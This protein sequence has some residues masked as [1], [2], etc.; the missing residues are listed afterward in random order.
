MAT[1]PW[2]TTRQRVRDAAGFT[3]RTDQLV[4]QAIAAASRIVE[5]ETHRRF[6]PTTATR[7][8]DWPPP[9]P[10]K[11][12]RLWLD[13]D[14]L[15][16]LT[17]LTI[18]GT[19]ATVSEFNLEPANE[20]P[21]YNRIEVDLSTSAAFSAGTT[22]QQAISIVGVW[23]FENRTIPAG[24]TAEDMTT[25]ETDL[26]VTNGGLIDVGDLLHIGDERLFVT[27]VAFEDTT[28]NT[29]DTMSADKADTTVPVADETGF[30]A[31][32]T[33]RID[34][35]EMLIRSVTTGNLNVLRSYNGTVL[36][37]HASAAD[38][39]ADRLCTVERA[40]TG[41]TATT[42]T[43]G[44]VITKQAYPPLIEQWCIAEA[45]VQLAQ[46][47]AGYA[48]TAGQGDNQRETIGLGL[49][50]IRERALSLYGRR[51]RTRVI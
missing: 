26:S 41:T 29:D 9:Q 34:D 32:E 12:W 5:A 46:Q 21:P 39:Y 51:I 11:P 47:S 13:A 33:I 6:Y 2:Y 23:G 20:G 50:D 45:V 40:A 8:F 30:L 17:S 28:V 49:V 37:S 14:E 22:T 10:A 24:T 48:R 15:V 16:T 19:A 43:S 1:D 44:A 7:V 18:A 38:V 27:E 3:E 4:D 25:S 35:E 42:S 36:A 31:G